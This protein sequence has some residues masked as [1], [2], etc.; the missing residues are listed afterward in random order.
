MNQTE[1]KN[2]QTR[3]LSS[4]QMQK[5]YWARLGQCSLFLFDTDHMKTQLH[6]EL[7]YG[8]GLQSIS[9]LSHTDWYNYITYTH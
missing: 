4:R 8:Y 9:K 5:M 7:K 2:L 1:T 6:T 3:Y